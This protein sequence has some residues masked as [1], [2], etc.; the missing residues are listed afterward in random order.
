M[1]VF[2]NDFIVMFITASLH[3]C[4]RE[5]Q[6]MYINGA[7]AWLKPYREMPLPALPSSLMWWCRRST[8]TR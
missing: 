3:V 4:K 8:C 6:T 5:A 7:G 2:F 1:N